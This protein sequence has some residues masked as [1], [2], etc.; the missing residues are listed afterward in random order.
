MKRTIKTF[1]L[2][3]ISSV[4]IAQSAM[5]SSHREAPNLTRL[6]T[7]DSTDFYAFNSYEEGRG[8]YL[9]MIAN[10]IPLQDAYGGPNYF[11]MDP[12]AVYSIHIDS[13]GDAV[14]DMTFQF[15]FESKL[16][17]NKAGVAIMI[18]PADNQRSV[19]VPLKNIGDYCR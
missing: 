2:S 3:L 14:E 17:N 19:K 6:P 5:A 18:G 16:P 4:I 11:A 7:L 12:A 9:T 10:Y 13:D 1:A 8:E 15:R